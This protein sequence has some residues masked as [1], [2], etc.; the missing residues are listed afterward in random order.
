MQV[1]KRGKRTTE[2]TTLRVSRKT[3][4]VVST[5]AKA[6]ERTADEIIWE[7]LE[8]LYAREIK[9]VEQLSAE[10]DADDNTP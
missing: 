4:V 3:A 6:K 1:R 5:I 10:A 2:A 8:K 7:M 9:L